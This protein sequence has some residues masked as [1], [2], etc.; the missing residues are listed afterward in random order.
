MA[1]SAWLRVTSAGFFAGSLVFLFLGGCFVDVGTTAGKCEDDGNPCTKD[2]CDASG[3]PSHVAVDD[4]A[5]L[6]CFLGENEGVCAGGM[7]ELSCKTQM[8]A[9]KCNS[10]ADCPMD[11]FCSTWACTMG[12]CIGTNGNEGMPFDPMLGDCKNKV[13]RSGIAKVENNDQDVPDDMT[14]GDCQK[15]ACSMGVLGTTANDNDVPAMDNMPGDCMKPHC[16]AGK[17]ETIVDTNDIRKPTECTIY[18]C[19]ADGT[20]APANAPIGQK[21]CPIMEQACDKYGMCVGCLPAGKDDYE[22]CKMNNGG[23]CPIPK[24]EGQPCTDKSE[25]KDECTD[26]VC[27][28]TTCMEACKSCSVPGSVG[29]CTN[30]PEYQEDDKY[31]TDLSCD[32]MVAGA[33]CNGMGKCL[34]IVGTPCT[35]DMQCY[36]GKCMNLKCLGAPGEMCGSGPVC[37]SGVCMMGACK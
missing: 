17:L 31:G 32:I 25:C 3:K 33:V 36:S 12:E 16:N 34:N 23:V 11:N 6:Q 37:A 4:K 27:C 13:C 24:C 35:M 8:T 26:G 18:G 19:N 10:K 5:K 29:K 28:D 30:I 22:K 21:S 9:C 20:E 1:R 15:P 2:T 7:C 14:L